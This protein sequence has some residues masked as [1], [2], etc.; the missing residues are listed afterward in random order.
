MVKLIYLLK[1]TGF[2]WIVFTMVLLTTPAAFA[3]Q[4]NYDQI[5]W[6]EDDSLNPASLSAEIDFELLGDKEFRIIL[7][8]TS[9]YDDTISDY[10]ATVMLTG[11]GFELNNNSIASGAV[12][13]TF[14]NGGSITDP[15]PYWGYDNAGIDKGYFKEGEVTTLSVNTV[16]STMTAAVEYSF[17]GSV[18]GNP[19]AGPN[20]GVLSSS[21]PAGTNAYPYFQDEV[22]IDVILT[23]NIGN[24][25]TFIDYVNDND[26]VI[27][28]GSPTAVIP[29]P[30]PATMLLLGTGLIGLA[31][32]GRK[33][34]GKS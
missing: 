24:W 4:V 31:G 22:I 6:Q 20:W 15:T 7:R 12:S 11:M 18:A 33:K 10:P 13:G 17:D 32:I 30:E 2:L 16:V 27:A 9:M 26:F 3:D 23:N 25:Y 5:I 34:F 29:V 28:F 21:Y 19:I 14:Y 8:N 1:M